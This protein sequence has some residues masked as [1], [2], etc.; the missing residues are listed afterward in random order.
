[1]DLDTVVDQ[2]KAL[3]AE[4]RRVSYRAIQVQFVYP[5]EQLDAVREELLYTHAAM[6]G[7]DGKGLVCL[8]A[9]AEPPSEPIGCIHTGRP[10]ASSRTSPTHRVV[11]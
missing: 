7:E 11:L 1:M 10:P 6:V 8:A 2:V 4:R 3:I 5:A 9:V